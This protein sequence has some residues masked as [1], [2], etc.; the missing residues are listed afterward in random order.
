MLSISAAQM[1]VFE[2]AALSRF[3]DDMVAHSHRFSPK[4]SN[5]LGAERLRAAV[6]AAIARAEGYGFSNRGPA[7]LFVELSFLFGSSFDD[8]PQYPWAAVALAGLDDQM[9][10]A[11]ALYDQTLVYQARVT[12]EDAA[13]TWVALRRLQQWKPESEESP[14]DQILLDAVDVLSDLFP[15]KAA[16]VGGAGLKALAMRGLAVADAAHL[17][18]W[19]GALLMTALMFG[20]GQGCADDLL[21]PW[22]NRTLN[23]P[24]IVDAD[25]RAAR[26]ERK[27]LVWLERVLTGYSG[28]A[29]AAR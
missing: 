22:I 6:R 11:A 29:G 15:E 16:F 13:H 5:V 18:T 19:R 27:A 21:Y 8:D 20:L 2:A 4:L 26:L 10:R 24:R 1:A 23:D 3:V 25:A 7:R 17:L 9:E 28:L 12:D 14:R